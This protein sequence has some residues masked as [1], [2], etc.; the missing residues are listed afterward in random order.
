MTQQ[1]F[2]EFIDRYC[3]VEN[4]D[5]DTFW[6]EIRAVHAAF[7]DHCRNLSPRPAKRA[8]IATIIE[9]LK[10]RPVQIRGSLHFG[11]VVGMRIN[12]WPSGGLRPPTAPHF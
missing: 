10:S 8:G 6:V 5:Y 9:Y 3:I 7:L 2:D 4:D 12:R 1:D 11:V